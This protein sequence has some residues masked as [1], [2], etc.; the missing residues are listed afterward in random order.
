MIV[1]F[2]DEDTETVYLT[3]RSVRF[4]MI[5]KVAFRKL[6]YLDAAISLRDL[7]QVPGNELEALKYDRQG[8]HSVRINRQ[9]RICFVWQDGNAHNVEIADPH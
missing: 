2:R 1:S 6:R 9:W 3:G 8:Q 7:A 5:E 4:R